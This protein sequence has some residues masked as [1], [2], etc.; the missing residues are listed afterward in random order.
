MRGTVP[1]VPVS[2]LP[3][4][5]IENLREPLFGGSIGDVAAVDE[6]ERD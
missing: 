1:A 6:P 4:D 2:A 3:L 5:A